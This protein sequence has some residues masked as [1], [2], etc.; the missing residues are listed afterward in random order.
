MEKNYSFDISDSLEVGENYISI[1]DCIQSSKKSE[2]Y[3][4]SIG[5]IGHNNYGLLKVIKENN[6]EL[7]NTISFHANDTS[8]YMVEMITH[9]KESDKKFLLLK[10]Y[11]KGSITK[12]IKKNTL[13]D[14]EK[15][16][17]MHDVLKIGCHLH[18]DNYIHADIKPDNF[19][20]DE[21]NKV[22]LG[23]L[24]FLQQLED[25][26]H[27]TI[28]KVCGTKGFKYSQGASYDMYDEIF[29]YV[30]TLYFIESEEVLLSI[31]E[32][33]QLDT[34]DDVVESINT[35]ASQKIA[36][37]S[38]TPLKNFLLL[39]LADIS[40]EA[41]TD[42]CELLER[43]EELSPRVPFID[44]PFPEKA[45][46]TLKEKIEEIWNTHKKPISIAI[47][48]VVVGLGILF[49]PTSEHST[50]PQ[51]T[52]KTTSTSSNIIKPS[53]IDN[54]TEEPQEQ[55]FAEQKP[56]EDK[57]V[58]MQ[59]T[60]EAAVIPSKPEVT[61]IEN[62]IINKPSVSPKTIKLAKAIKKQELNYSN[63]LKIDYK[64]E[65]KMGEYL[66]IS[67]TFNKPGYLQLLLIDP[68]G[69]Q[70]F[71]FKKAKSFKEQNY[72]ELR[73]LKNIRT[74]KPAGRH[75]ITAIYTAKKYNFTAN[76][77][78]DILRDLP[79]N[80]YNMEYVHIFEILVIE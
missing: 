49:Y 64:K 65:L 75:Y 79:N 56:L 37:L 6:N 28:N 4:V 16:T 7:K 74:S 72:K 20:I 2:V 33:C 62:A 53:P 57:P 11:D 73:E 66:D 9:G 55:V 43:Y 34:E 12:Y 68:E 13:S 45:E 48:L 70:H 8:N 23:D 35:F 5:D 24:E 32:L 54:K 71:V 27:D 14:E 78:L 36:S 51:D 18:K 1:V 80:S 38:H 31:E 69:N 58:V 29:A 39:C 61:N 21:E 47:P 26:Q 50:T 30:S 44:D 25:I 67:F 60:D 17:L 59:N 46:S 19:F 76:N 52:N 41:S 40:N 3:K 22:R 15:D 10:F 63:S 42:C 77:Y